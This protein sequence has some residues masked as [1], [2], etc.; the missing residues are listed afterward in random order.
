MGLCDGNAG[1]F[2]GLHSMGLPVAFVYAMAMQVCVMGLG[3]VHLPVSE[4]RMI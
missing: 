3:L 4:N 2:E 1:L